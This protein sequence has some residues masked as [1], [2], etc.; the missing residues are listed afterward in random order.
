MNKLFLIS[1]V[2]LFSAFFVPIRAQELRGRV[3]SEGRPV[4]YANVGVVSASVP[5]GG[6]TDGRG[7][8]HFGVRETDSITL[9]ISCTG[10]EPQEHRIRVG[11]NEVRTFDI[12]LRRSATQLDVVDVTDERIRSSSFTQIDIH[13][14]ENTVGPT[15]GVEALLKTLPDVSSGNELSSQYSVR[16][17]SFDENLVY[18][19][20]VEVYRPQ[21]IRS[22]QQEGLSIINPDMVDHVMFSPGGFDATYGDRMSSVLDIIYSR[23]LERRHSL[24]LSLLGG[25][26]SAQGRVGDRFAYSVGFRQHSNKYLFRSLDTEGQYTSSY[27]DLQAVL[28]YK[29]NDSLD[30]SLLA[31]ATRNRYSLVP[32]AATTSFGS[33]TEWLELRVYFDGL[34]VDQYNTL[35]GSLVLDYHPNDDLQLRWTTS[36]QRSSEQE[37][38][39]IQDQYMLYQVGVGEQSGDTNHFDRG[40]GTFLE[41]ARNRLDLGIYSTEL[42]VVKYALLGSWDLGVKG[43]LET[44]DDRMREWK[45]VDSAGYSFPTDHH[46]PGVD[47]TVPYNPVLQR[48]FNVSNQIANL[49]AIGYVQRELSLY[50]RHDD[51]VK[52]SAGLRGQYYCTFDPNNSH[53]S[54]VRQSSAEG[55]SQDLHYAETKNRLGE[56]LNSQFILSPRLM[57]SYNPSKGP[58]ILYKLT[59]G[60][61]QQPYMYRELRRADGSLSACLP[62]QCSYQATGSADWNLRLWNKPFRLTADI[63]YK[64]ITH[65]VPYTIDN[66]RIRYNPDQEAV[67]Y[68]A[69]VSLRINGDFAPGL[70]SWASVSYMKTQEDILGDGLGWLSRPTDQRFS[71]KIFLQD[72]MP[73]IPCWRMSLSLLYGTGTPVTHPYQTSRAVEY[74]LPPYFRVDWGNT[75]QLTRFERVRNSKW[76]RIFDDLSV[77]VEVFNLFNY[78]NVVSYLWVA[79]Y[80]N[81]YYRVPNYLTARQF[82]IKL[83]ATF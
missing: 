76:G 72:Y 8:Y 21:L 2:V 77:G 26:A 53:F 48:F 35:L 83:S 61:Y 78:R 73:E 79:D 52:L 67:G 44:V 38:Y 28:G 1:V 75:I 19:N 41:H 59:M 54:T 74:R 58:D 3:T 56:I 45:W 24:S 17:G 34:E 7:Y 68:A 33:F 40:V 32:F 47:D 39:D 51:E 10:Y 27:T 9:R 80:S 25:T 11:R 69:G 6:V 60:V 37:L 30:L 23:P 71:F 36:A 55:K 31:I 65:L 46:Q 63:Y 66:L 14:I 70:E 16:G 5:Y 81:H 12:E 43:Q 18:I 64:Y 49:R 62:A 22:G 29:V 4:E 15:A 20:G 42:K 57:A 82:N 50:T 13:R